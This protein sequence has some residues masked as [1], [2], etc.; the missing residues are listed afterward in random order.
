M[1]CV[2]PNLGGECNFTHPPCW[3]F[4]NNSETV[5]AVALTFCTIQQHFITNIRTKFGIPNLPQPPDIGEN[6]Y[7]GISHSDFRISD[8]A[9]IKQNCYKSRTSDDID[10][11]LGPETK[12]TSKKIDNNFMSGNCDDIVI[13]PVCGQFGPIR[14]P[15]S[16]RIICKT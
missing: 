15:D 4:L 9:S 5:K 1:R 11:K 13:F 8:Q 2:K 12:A 14:K 3:F 16:G 7:K 6:S 10:I